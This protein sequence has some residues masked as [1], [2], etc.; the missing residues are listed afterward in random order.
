VRAAATPL[1]VDEGGVHELTL[2]A[3]ARPKP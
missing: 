3:T 2:R 1:R